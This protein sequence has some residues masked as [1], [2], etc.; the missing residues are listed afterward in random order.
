[1]IRAEG[2]SMA[3]GP[4]RPTVS[5]DH[6][7]AMPLVGVGT[8]ALTGRQCFQAVRY[9]L[10]VGY[11]HLDTATMYFNEG[12]VGQAV[13]DSAVPREEVFVTTKLPPPEA[14]GRERRTG[15]VGWQ[16]GRRRRRRLAGAAAAGGQVAHRGHHPAG[17][18]DGGGGRIGF[19]M[20]LF[21]AGLAYAAP[22]LQDQ[23]RVG[24]LAGSLVAAAVGTLVLRGSLPPRAT[25]V[26]SPGR[27]S[28]DSCP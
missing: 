6:A 12:E 4:G 28:G 11:R 7:G 17:D 3:S 19:T 10:E 13:L 26:A 21:I 5:L 14:A 24:N 20:S 15:P 22:D 2:S 1:M 18:G 16:A 8:G 9:A 25:P 27:R 23:A